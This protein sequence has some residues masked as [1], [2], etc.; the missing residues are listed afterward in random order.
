MERGSTAAEPSSILPSLHTLAPNPTTLTHPQ[1]PLYSPPPH[2]P[3]L[4]IG[5]IHP[6]A[7]H[8]CDRTGDRLE[9]N[10]CISRS[11]CGHQRYVH[12]SMCCTSVRDCV[13]HLS[14][15][16]SY[17]RVS[18]SAFL[19][20]WVCSLFSWVWRVLCFSLSASGTLSRVTHMDPSPPSPPLSSSASYHYVY[21]N[22]I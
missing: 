16:V 12:A 21:C 17:F 3:I 11:C 8:G 18:V 2:S 14:V 1:Y 13:V 4:P 10:R 19:R 15:Y 5:V 22:V 6:Q 7:S 20:V 9:G